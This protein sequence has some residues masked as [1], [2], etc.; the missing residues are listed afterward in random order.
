MIK[1]S[2]SVARL[3]Q[4]RATYGP[5]M[6]RAPSGQRCGRQ[7][8]AVCFNMSTWRALGGNIMDSVADVSLC[9]HAWNRGW[10]LWSKW[11]CTAEVLQRRRAPALLPEPTGGSYHLRIFPGFPPQSRPS[12]IRDMGIPRPV[13]LIRPSPGAACNHLANPSGNSPS[14]CQHRQHLHP[15]HMTFHCIFLF[16]N[17]S[18]IIHLPS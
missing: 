4:T 18:F 7:C 2:F 9:L 16:H 5:R 8:G 14:R 3:P 6:I 1:K 15:F 12:V 10:A 17:C 11:K 13:A